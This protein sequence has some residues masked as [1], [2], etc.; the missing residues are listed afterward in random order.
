MIKLK[1]YYPTSVDLQKAEEPYRSVLRIIDKLKFM[2]PKG[3]KDVSTLFKNHHALSCVRTIVEDLI[4]NNL[5]FVSE[6]QRLWNNLFDERDLKYNEFDRYSVPY[7]H[8]RGIIFGGVY[9]VLSLKKSVS[10]EYLLIMEEFIKRYPDAVPFFDVFKKAVVDSTSMASASA[11]TQNSPDTIVISSNGAVSADMQKELDEVKRENEKL[12][13]IIEEYTGQKDYKKPFF[14]V[15]QIAIATYFLF[16]EKIN[17]MDNQSSWAK[18]VSM[19]CRRDQQ[20]IRECFGRINSDLLNLKGDAEIVAKSL[21]DS[22]PYLADIIR[23][24]F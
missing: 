12:K 4:Q 16:Q 11:A 1:A 17:V 22:F 9:Y 5:S 13:K 8:Y 18:I 6:M 21:D 20:N 14:T 7:I 15:N 19:I 3:A 10:D 2:K 23:K 24:N